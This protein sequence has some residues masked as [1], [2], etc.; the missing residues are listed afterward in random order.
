MLPGRK[1]DLWSFIGDT[2]RDGRP[3]AMIT[4]GLKDGRVLVTGA[5]RGIGFAAAKA[6]LNE[7]ANV[8]IN[9]SNNDRLRNAVDQ[10]SSLG[11]VHGVLADLATKEGIEEVVGRAKDILGGIDTLVYVTGSP[12]QGPFMDQEYEDWEHAAK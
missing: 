10:L 7:G 5:S 1:P 6:F 2:I 4:S 8:L 3:N 12:K 11:Q 9:S